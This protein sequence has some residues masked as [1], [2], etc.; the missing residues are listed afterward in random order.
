MLIGKNLPLFTTELWKVQNII[1]L[2]MMSDI[3]RKKNIL[4][5]TRN[6]SS[7][8]TRI[9]NSSTSV[10]KQFSYLSF[11]IQELISGNV[12]VSKTQIILELNIKFSKLFKTPIV[13]MKNIYFSHIRFTWYAFTHL[14]IHI[15][16][17]CIK[18]YN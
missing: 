8:E 13:F 1:S 15:S 12:E 14:F 3:F 10:F 18:F 7:F 17:I 5:N 6:K 9:I 2:D 11:K 16:P 4:Y